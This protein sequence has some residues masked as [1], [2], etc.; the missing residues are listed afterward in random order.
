MYGT[1]ASR[2]TLNPAGFKTFS[3]SKETPFSH[4]PSVGKDKRSFGGLCVLPSSTNGRNG[5]TTASTKRPTPGLNNALSCDRSVNGV[6]HLS[7]TFRSATH[8]KPSGCNA[9]TPASDAIFAMPSIVVDSTTRSNFFCRNRRTIGSEAS[10]AT[11]AAKSPARLSV[12]VT[13]PSPAPTSSS[14]PRVPGDE[15]VPWD[16]SAPPG[17]SPGMSSSIAKRSRA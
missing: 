5:I 16:E 1:L 14:T 8:S 13:S 6:S 7:R 2:S 10:V 11:T 3:K 4:V 12:S 15:S 9:V 17:I